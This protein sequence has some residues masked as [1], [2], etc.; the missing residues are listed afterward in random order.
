M[1]GEVLTGALA[2]VKKNGA[3]V[4]HMRNIRWSENTQRGEVQGIGTLLIKEAPPTRHGGSGSCDFYAIDF[5]SGGIPQGID[6]NVQTNQEFEDN[7]ALKD[8][9]QIDIFRK[10]EDAIDERGIKRAKLV[11]YAI[12][13]RVFLTTHGGDISEGSLSGENQGFIYL[14]PI[15]F[16]S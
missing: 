15:I 5:E 1:A 9:L 13:R 16:P 14:D 2:L 10:V 7:L 3:V 12:L 6:R 11:P 8:G 4:G